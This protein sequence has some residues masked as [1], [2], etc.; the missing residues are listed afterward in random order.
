V[1]VDLPADHGKGGS[2]GLEFHRDQ[3]LPAL[4]G[5]GVAD[6]QLGFAI[7]AEIKA[8][9]KFP[10]QLCPLQDPCM[11]GTAANAMELDCLQGQLLHRDAAQLFGGVT[12]RSAGSPEVL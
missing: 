3:Q 8:A 1:A 4:L 11:A 10:Q 5:R 12:D 2:S 6:R 7:V 9:A